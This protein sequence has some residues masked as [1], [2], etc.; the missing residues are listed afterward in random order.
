MIYVQWWSTT[1]AKYAI[2]CQS[3]VKS[4]TWQ[5]GDCFTK[6]K[7][8][9]ISLN[10]QHMFHMN[11]CIPSNITKFGVWVWHLNSETAANRTLYLT[12]WGLVN[13]G[14][15]GHRLLNRLVIQTAA[16]ELAAAVCMT[17][18]FKNH[19]SK[20]RHAGTWNDALD[21]R[22]PD[23]LSETLLNMQTPY[24]VTGP[25]WVKLCLG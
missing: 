4:Q 2:K 8:S 10:F 12:H 15:L 18:H 11:V 13:F 20:H 19:W 24:G 14:N 17:S 22:N 25:Q 3:D 16:A 7:T 9:P 21:I 6:L 5:P 23:L 1:T